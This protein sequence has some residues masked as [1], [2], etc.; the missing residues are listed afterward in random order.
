[1]DFNIL[2]EILAIGMPAMLQQVLISVGFIVI[3]NFSKWFWNKL[4]SSFLFQHQ[5]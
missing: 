3:Q 2:K 5:E 4:Y 1:M